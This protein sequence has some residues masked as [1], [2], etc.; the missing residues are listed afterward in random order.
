VRI[1]DRIASGE[2]VESM[3]GLATPGTTSFWRKAAHS[4][5]RVIADEAAQLFF[6]SELNAWNLGDGAAK[7]GRQILPQPFTWVEWKEPAAEIVSGTASP[8]SGMRYA[9]LMREEYRTT[10]VVDVSMSALVCLDRGPIRLAPLLLAVRAD[11]LGNVMDVA[12]AGWDTEID[13]MFADMDREVVMPYLFRHLMPALLAIGLMHCKTVTAQTVATPGGT[14]GRKTGGKFAGLNY[15][16]ISIGGS[17]GDNLRANRGRG[18]GLLPQHMVRAHIRK[19]KKPLFGR[20]GG[21]TGDLLI[22][23]HVRGNP[24]HGTINKEYHV[25]D[26]AAQ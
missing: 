23:G 18:Q 1:F 25:T 2:S 22:P 6:Q 3:T 11:G 14:R 5:T 20:E 12:P 16:R 9:V 4:A 7:F 24:T 21:M 8:L 17:T 10:D 26:E 15:R 13:A 19:V